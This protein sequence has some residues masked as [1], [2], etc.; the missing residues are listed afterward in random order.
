MFWNSFPELNYTRLLATKVVG[1]KGA[2]SQ[3]LHPTCSPTM[4]VLRTIV[5]FR[6]DELTQ[7]HSTLFGHPSYLAKAQQSAAG[8]SDLL[9]V[10]SKIGDRIFAS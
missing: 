3:L 5:T 6:I 10:E 2:L 7:S 9:M 8:T 4:G 1:T